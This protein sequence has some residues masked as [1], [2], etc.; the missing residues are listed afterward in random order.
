MYERLA[1]IRGSVTAETCEKLI[2]FHGASGDDVCQAVLIGTGT[3][4][5]E[6]R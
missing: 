4:H 5:D 6:G 3:V 1:K 2:Q